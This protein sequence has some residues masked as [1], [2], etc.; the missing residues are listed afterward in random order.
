MKVRSQ[1]DKL[2][3]RRVLL[4]LFDTERDAAETIAALEQARSG[5]PL[6]ATE[7]EAVARLL[8]RLDVLAGQVAS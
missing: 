5:S 8:A 2:V 1:V 4:S 3:G 6:D 7:R